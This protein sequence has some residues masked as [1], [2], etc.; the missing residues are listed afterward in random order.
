MIYSCE[1]PNAVGEMQNTL[2]VALSYHF[3]MHLGL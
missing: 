1:F 3:N 2:E